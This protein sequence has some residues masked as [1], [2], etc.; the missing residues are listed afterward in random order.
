M[1]LRSVV[2]IALVGVWLVVLTTV[3]VVTM[4]TRSDAAGTN[5]SAGPVIV[6]FAVPAIA[7]AVWRLR[8]PIVT[9]VTIAA[10]TLVSCLC[11][12]SVLNDPSSTAALGV[13]APGVYAA[14]V[15]MVGL[16]VQSFA[17]RPASD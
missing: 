3:V 2:A 17:V 8:H 6:A 12:A 15:V 1:K 7:L 13:P 11:A 4:V 5:A 9:I 16:A 14:G 10:A